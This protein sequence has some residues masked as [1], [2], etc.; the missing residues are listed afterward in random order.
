MIQV[1]NLSKKY[2]LGPKASANTTLR[3]SLASVAL[4]PVRAVARFSPSRI[5]DESVRREDFWAL[6]GVDFEVH[7]GEVLGVIGRNGA[8]KSTLLKIL[9][10]ITEPTHGRV[11]VKGRSAA[12]LEVG[13]GFHPELTGRENIF[14]NG[15]ILGMPRTEIKSKFDEIVDFAE[16]RKFIDTPVKHYSSGMYVR[17]AFSVAAHLEP[18]ILVVD[19]VLAVGDTSFQRKCLGRMDEVAREGRTVLF[20]SHN[21]AA[22]E[23][24]CRRVLVLD[25]G[26]VSADDECSIAVEYYSR[27]LTE[28]SQ[29]TP[30]ELRQD[31]R[32]TGA[33]RVVDFHVED[34]EHIRCDKLKSGRD[35]YLCFTFGRGHEW[36]GSRFAFDYT[37]YDSRLIPLFRASTRTQGFEFEMSGESCVLRCFIPRLPLAAGEY[38]I[39]VYSEVGGDVADWL[40]GAVAFEVVDGDYWGSGR[41][42]NGAFGSFLL[43]HSWAMESGTESRALSRGSS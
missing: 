26:R 6:R 9:S 19:E 36:D 18:D 38:V 23:N 39:G 7:R 22:V 35:H 13:T 33:V 34:S 5:A 12:L 31:R 16:V 32:G 37:L 29:R 27:T 10:Q 14:L 30:L 1:E 8:G 11:R 15:A 2:R 21:M 24:L 3:E 4:A 43:E 40:P 17:L 41:T 25:E 28:N 20:V 42:E